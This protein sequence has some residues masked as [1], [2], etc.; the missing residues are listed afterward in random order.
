MADEYEE[1]R[2]N[3]YRDDPQWEPW[4]AEAVDVQGG[5]EDES[6]SGSESEIDASL[7]LPEICICQHCR[8]FYMGLLEI[9]VRNTKMP[10]DFFLIYYD[11]YLVSYN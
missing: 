8:L 9:D 11:F 3:P 1:A 10:L 7:D 6:S 5:A 2:R 4:H